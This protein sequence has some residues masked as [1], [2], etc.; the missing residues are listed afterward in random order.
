MKKTHLRNLFGSIAVLATVFMVAA[1][2]S[3]TSPKISHHSHHDC[4]HEAAHHDCAEHGSVAV[5]AAK[6]AADEKCTT[7]KG[8]G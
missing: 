2:R 6:S 1:S 3:E 7:C 5:A 8:K 4:D